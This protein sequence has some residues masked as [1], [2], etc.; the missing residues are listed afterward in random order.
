M[1]PA[2]RPGPYGCWPTGSSALPPK[3]TTSKRGSP[4]PSTGPPQGSSNAT[5]SVSTPPP[6][7]S[8]PPATTP[9]G[10]AAMPRSPHCVA[11]V[12]SRPPPA[13][14]QRHRLNQGGD[15]QAGAALYRIALSRLRWDPR[16]Q[17]Y[18]TRRLK[19]GKSEREIIRCLIEALHRPRN[20]PDHHRVPTK[21][22]QG[23][24][25]A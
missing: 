5:V 19:Q 1:P 11:Q 20:L 25:A 3:S 13:R 15:R 8:S 17:D 2:P 9:N 16:T 12:P 14:P 7:C 21:P 6:A 22:N 24:S 10:S 23:P 4:T 18:M